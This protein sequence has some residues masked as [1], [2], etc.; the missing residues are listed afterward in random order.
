MRLLDTSHKH[1]EF[2]VRSKLHTLWQNVKN[3]TENVNAPRYADYGG[4]GIRMYR[5]WRLSFESFAEY[6]LALP[7]CPSVKKLRSVGGPR[8]RVTLDRKDNDK[9]YAPGNLQWANLQTQGRNKRNNVIVAPG[10]T[11]V[12]ACESRGLNY[13]LVWQRIDRGWSIERALS[14]PT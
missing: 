12:E 5:R 10:I 11:L 13:K 6:V 3:R 9:N 14:T 7:G 8:M 1:Y 2:P 4:R